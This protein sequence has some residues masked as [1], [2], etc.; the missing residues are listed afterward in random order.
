MTPEREEYVAQDAS[1]ATWTRRRAQRLRGAVL[2][3]SP[4]AI[5]AVFGAA[6]GLILMA[7]PDLRRIAL[8]GYQRVSAVILS[9]PPFEIRR[10]V[11]EGGA[12][13]TDQEVVRALG[14]A[15]GAAD[16]LEFDPRIA[17]IGV[18]ALGW[19]RRAHVKKLPPQIVEVVIEE[20]KL[21][22]RWRRGGRLALV[23]LAGAVI[24]DDLSAESGK[25][26]GARLKEFL[27]APLVVG[28]GADQAIAEA[29]ELD[30][31]AAA[32]GLKVIGWT[33]IGH[34]SWDLEL[35]E[36]PRV[37]LPSESPKEA[38]SLFIRWRAETDLLDHR[39]V[40]LDFRDPSAPVGRYGATS[41]QD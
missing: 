39:F 22:A 30:R 9:R 40:A 34:R 11:I 6:L 8:D 4:M 35:L 26:G 41:G 29:V 13:V 23:D 31:M 10:V 32:A 37:M 20:R 2:R 1:E 5:A 14:L 17:R 24:A 12:H 25:R 27:D 15:D 28:P 21:A 7:A 18:E 16:S 33:R 36:G 3:P 38:L 19:V